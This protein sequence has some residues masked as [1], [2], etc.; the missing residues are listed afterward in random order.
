MKVQRL[1]IF[2]LKNKVIM[3]VKNEGTNLNSFTTTIISIMP[4]EPL[5]VH[6]S[7]LVAFVWSC[8]IKNMLV[9]TTKETKV[10]M[11]M[12]NVNLKDAQSIYQKQSPRLRNPRRT[13]M[14]GKVFTMK[15][16]SHNIKKL[17][18]LLKHVLFPRLSYS[19]KTLKCVNQ[20]ILFDVA[21]F[22]GKCR[23]KWFIFSK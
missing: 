20:Q 10:V 16:A 3:Y 1:A 21:K 19:K 15:L 14:N 2:N 18:T 6:Q 8:Y 9:C 23:V 12:K 11:G 13:N 5:Q 22:M 4:C 17:K 7:C